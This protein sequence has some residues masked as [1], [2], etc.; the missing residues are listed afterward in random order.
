M[1]AVFILSSLVVFIMNH[2]QL[3]QPINGW[4]SFIVSPNTSL[5]IGKFFTRAIAL[6]VLW[7]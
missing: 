2:G 1:N 3:A 6:S 5:M 4:Q 7:G